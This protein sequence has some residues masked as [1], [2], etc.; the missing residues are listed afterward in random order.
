MSNVIQQTLL[1]AWHRQRLRSSPSGWLSGN[2]VC[3]HHRGHRPDRRGR[4]GLLNDAAGGIT[5]SCF[6]C[7][8][9]AHYRPGRPL[10]YKMRQLLS[11]M[12]VDEQSIRFLVLEAIRLKDTAVDIATEKIIEEV[13]FEPRELPQGSL[14]FHSW[15]EFF[16]L[17]G[18][19]YCPQQFLDAVEYVS[20]RAIDMS[21][22]D[23]Y[24]TDNREKHIDHRVI[25]PFIHQTQTVGYTAR[26]IAPWLSPRYYTDSQPGYVFNLDR[27]QRQW[28]SVIV[29]EGIFDAL[30][31]D[32]V[33]VM[34]NEINES[35]AD[36]IDSLGKNVIVVPDWDVNGQNLIEQAIEYNWNVSF[37]VWRDNCKDINDA[38][39]KYG[40]LFVLKTIFDSV[41]YNSLKIRLLAKKT[42][43]YNA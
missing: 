26:G 29:C 38:V 16:V 2:A 9:T 6:N 8:F 23:F 30:S 17:K 25:I 1:D 36:Q 27:Q 7:G 21:R 37:P 35:Q 41:E 40:K 15:A 13:K 14:S 24:W 22:Y 31:V 4:G 11:W 43:W 39:V 20:D 42:R 32:A 34:H 12:G 10:F 19:D 5:Y 33:A 3:C 18:L 28:S